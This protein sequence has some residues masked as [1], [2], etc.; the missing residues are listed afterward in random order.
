MYRIGI[1][2]G[3]SGAHRLR[4]YRGSCERL[5]GHN[6]I[7]RVELESEKIG[8]DG[9]VMDFRVLKKK[10]QSILNEMDHN[11]LNSLSAFKNTEPTAENI[12]Y[13]I[14]NDIQKK[15]PKGKATVRSVRVHESRDSWAE[16]VRY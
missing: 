8:Q 2:S 5:H 6:W 4:R 10:L 13:K 9:L 12:A 14:F 11:Y 1:E 3:F 16:Y 7:V 15:L